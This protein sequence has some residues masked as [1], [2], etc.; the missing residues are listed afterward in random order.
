MD[1]VL[2]LPWG[3]GSAQAAFPGQIAISRGDLK[4]GIGTN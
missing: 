3:E 4:A 2:H 1:V